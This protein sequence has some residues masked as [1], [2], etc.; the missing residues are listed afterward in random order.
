MVSFR[1]KLEQGLARH[2][3]QVVYKVENLDYDALLVIGGT[4]R[5]GDLRAVRKR[6]IPIVQRLDGMNWLHRKRKTGL[7]HFVRA[8]ASNLILN[9]IRSRFADSIIYQSDF[10]RAWWERVHGETPVPYS[11]VFNGVDLN[12]Y[13]PHEE[14]TRPDNVFRMLLV[15]GNLGGGYE[16]GL[17]H[18]LELGQ[19]LNERL[20]RRLELMVV[21]RVDP[22]LRAEVMRSTRFPIRWVGLVP[23]DQIPDLDRSAHVFFAA[24]LNPACPNAVI[25]AMACGLPVTAYATGA[26]PE[27]VTGDAGRLASFGG[28]PWQLENPDKNALADAAEEII[29]HQNRYRVGARHRAEEIFGLD[30][31]IDGYLRAF[32][33][34]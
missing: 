15:E 8:E 33:W 11:I 2:G 1:H 19:M 6:G 28:D 22:F 17:E 3:V 14:D 27:L 10:S 34:I 21:G 18:A 16:T 12:T 25:E 24:D 9:T 20:S 23:R 7:Q 29:I 13:A 26:L 30:Q 5:L 31:M 4:R 32:G